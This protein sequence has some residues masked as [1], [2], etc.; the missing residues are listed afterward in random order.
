[1]MET[2]SMNRT[3]YF[4]ARQRGFTLVELLVVIAIIGVLVSLLLPA[5]QAA[6]EAAR[7]NTCLSKIR[8][9]SLACL[10]YESS[11]SQFPPMTGALNASEDPDQEEYG[12]LAFILPYIEQQS[13]RDN[14]DD[15]KEWY[16]P[17]NEIPTLTPLQPA[18][19]PSRIPL[20]PVNLG[21]G[22]KGPGFPD[23]P[24]SELR[25]HYFAVMGANTSDDTNIPFF[26][27][28]RG[29][30]YSLEI[31]QASSSSRRDPGCE[32]GNHGVIADS[33]IMYRYSET[34]MGHITDGTS[35]TFLI[36]ESAFGDSEDTTRPWI[37]GSRGLWLYTG[38]NLR[39]T[40][41]SGSRIGGGGPPARNDIG[42]GSD[43]PGGCHFAMAD[44]SATYFSENIE[45]LVLFNLATRNDGNVT[46]S[47]DL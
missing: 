9:L 15:A 36:G 20:E 5:V 11:R 3:P 29:S 8:Q 28:D 26:C 4:L 32:D 38:K 13:L 39:Y 7:R 40:I 31:Q 2:D 12:W 24:E 10:N 19:C 30:L 41:N 14:I 35:N 47:S 37:V 6:R 45:L 21:G 33:G 27:D 43:H 18:R 25:S 34:E 42:F 23:Q 16:E 1:M 44:G 46:N 22:N 17:E